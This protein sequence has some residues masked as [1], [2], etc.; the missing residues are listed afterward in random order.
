MG[1]LRRAGS[2]RPG[3]A[4]GRFSPVSFPPPIGYD[5]GLQERGG[6][7]MLAMIRDWYQTLEETMGPAWS[8]G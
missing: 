6:Q 4:C 1:Q 8:G 2:T 5:F 7:L 3:R